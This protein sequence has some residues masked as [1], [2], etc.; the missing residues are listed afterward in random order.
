MASRQLR[1]VLQTLR[2]ATLPDDAAGRTDG[3]LLES[4]L[5]SREEAAFAALVRRHGP[6]VWGV[7]HRILRS[8]QDAEDAFQATFLVLVRKAASVVPREMVAN[9]LYGV[10]R[11]TALYARVTAAR[12][13]ARE[14]QVTAMPEPALEHNE[15]WDE[16]QPLL[17]EALGRLPDK[18]RA[19]LV[20]CD[21]E[22]KT[23]K[24]AARHF[25]LPEGTV[26]S[27]LATARTMLARRL[28]RHDLAVT[29]GA[30][31]AVVSQNVALAG[32][33]ASVASAAIKAAS[34]RAAGQAVAPGVVSVKAVA[35]AEGVLK[36]MLLTK[37]K[38]AVAVLLVGTL[39]F[40]MGGFGMHGGRHSPLGAAYGKEQK[41]GPKK[42]PAQEKATPKTDQELIQGTWEFVSLTVGG[43]KEWNASAPPK[44]LTFASDKVRF[45]AVN[46][47][48]KEV[49]FHSRFKLEVGRRPKE[50]DM[51]PLDGEHKETIKGLYELQGDTLRLCHPAQPGGDRPKSLESNEGSTDYLWTLK[52]V[53]VIA[54]EDAQIR[55]LAW[56]ANGKTLATVGIVYDVVEFTDGDGKPRGQGACWPN[57]TIK[58]WDAKTGELQRSLAEEQH[59]LIAAIAFSADGKSAAV[60]VSKH[61]QDPLKFQAEVRLVDAKTWA[62]KHKVEVAGFASALA[63]SPDGTRLA[64]GGRSRLAAKGSQV[65]LWD[66]RQQKV[67]GGTVDA[68]DRVTCLAFSR[69]GKLLAAGDEDGRIRLLD[70]RNGEPI[71]VLEGHGEWVSGVGFS[72]DGKTL[73]SG[74]ADKTVK[75]WDV[76]AGKLRRTLEG[77]KTPFTALVVSTDGQLFATAEHRGEKGSSVHLWD[78]KTGEV[79]KVFPD[80]NLPVNALAFSPDGGTLAIGAGD[81]VKLGPDTGIG[82]IK[83]PGEFKLWRVK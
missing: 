58:L 78:M 55:S 25:H 3:Q 15:L 41:D 77:D 30:L 45:V 38:I 44:C 49:A 70:G 53:A 67:I 6:M 18:Y 8:H 65:K 9:W 63:F 2:G 56:S 73:V 10:A 69:D 28:A 61:H 59:T 82:R 39:L 19:V 12:R 43:K 81:G 36:T 57:S 34:L 35:L 74:S 7:C 32:V 52:K 71:R 1:R 37:L 4:Y 24:E 83:T 72:A 50:I 68:G 16:L 46:G 33:P 17:D 76:E 64:V 40:G 20:L 29:G 42:L 14:K 54:R 60:S 48:G 26:A 31:A 47:D 75:L 5:H 21:L 62:L 13:G 80:E 23:R 51:T 11:Q 66:V 79:K 27:R 22:G